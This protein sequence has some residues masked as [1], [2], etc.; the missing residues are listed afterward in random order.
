MKPVAKINLSNTQDPLEALSDWIRKTKEHNELGNILLNGDAIKALITY[1]EKVGKYNIRNGIVDVYYPTMI[2]P[3]R[4]IIFYMAKTPASNK[5]VKD[6]LGW[7]M[8]YQEIGED[9]SYIFSGEYDY[10]YMGV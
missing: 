1:G 8:S 9:I 4:H 3:I 5:D 7:V 10:V 6:G 2:N